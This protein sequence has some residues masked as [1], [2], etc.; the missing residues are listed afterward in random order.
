[1]LYGM[2]MEQNNNLSDEVVIG[3]TL[4][5]CI[6]SWIAQPG[7]F[8]YPLIAEFK[9]KYEV[10]NNGGWTMERSGDGSWAQKVGIEASSKRVDDS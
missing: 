3:V 7:L 4:D 5:P 8:G 2:G 9:Q 10:A 1:M 6:V